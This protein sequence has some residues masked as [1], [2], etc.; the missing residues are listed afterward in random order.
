MFC[1]ECGRPLPDANTAF[2]PHCGNRV[3]IPIQPVR[4]PVTAQTET[5]APKRSRLCTAALL[6]GVGTFVFG[7]LTL[8]CKLTQGIAFRM[9]AIVAVITFFFAPLACCFGVF[10]VAARIRN[11]D[12]KGMPSA[13]IGLLLGL[14]FGLLAAY[15]LFIRIFRA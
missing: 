7:M 10:G 2:C 11:R 1:P 4:I 5:A 3:E 6:L 14:A 12:K 9:M 13:L 15:C 8:T